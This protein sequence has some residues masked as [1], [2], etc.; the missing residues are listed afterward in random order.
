MK[1]NKTSPYVFYCSDNDGQGICSPVVICGRIRSFG[2]NGIQLNSVKHNENSQFASQSA[3]LVG[4]IVLWKEMRSN[5]MIWAL[6][7]FG[8]VM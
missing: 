1:G 4:C 3:W 6:K 5:E 7:T 8:A 2:R